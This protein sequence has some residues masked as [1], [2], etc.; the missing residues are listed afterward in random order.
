[1]GKEPEVVAGYD[2]GELFFLQGY[3]LVTGQPLWTSDIG[4]ARMMTPNAA[5]WAL[6]AINKEGAPDLEGLH[7]MTYAQAAQEVRRYV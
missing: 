1:M 5:F 7:S 4:E 3:N 2:D 6:Y